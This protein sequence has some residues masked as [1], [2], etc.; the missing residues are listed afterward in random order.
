MF[1]VENEVKLKNGSGLQLT[2][3]RVESS[4]K[5]VLESIT[6]PDK[7]MGLKGNQA[8]SSTQKIRLQISHR[9]EHLIARKTHNNVKSFTYAW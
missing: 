3:Q 7:N 4:F 1:W 6:V 8:T 2:V 9:Q 5:V